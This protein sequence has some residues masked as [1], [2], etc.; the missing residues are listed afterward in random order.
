MLGEL[1]NER[2]QLSDDVASAY[3][4]GLRRRLDTVLV[5]LSSLAGLFTES[6]VR[7]PAWRF[8]ELGRRVERSLCLLSM[9]ETVVSPAHPL[10]RASLFDYVLAA[11]ESLVAYRRRYRSDTVLDA[12]VDLLVR[13]DAN[14]RALHFQL[15]QLRTQ[16]AM[17]PRRDGSAQLA[18]RI[19]AAS[20]ALIEV[21][22]LPSDADH[23]GA[24]GRREAIDRFVHAARTRS[25]TSPT[26]WSS[27]TST[28]RRG[29]ARCSAS[30]D[31]LL[32]ASPHLVSLRPMDEQRSE[33]RPSE[34]AVD[35]EPRRAVNQHRRDTRAGGAIGMER[36]LWQSRQLVHDYRAARDARGGRAIRRRRARV[37]GARGG[38][39]L[40][41]VMAHLATGTNADDID[42]QQF[43]LPSPFIPYLFE[44]HSLA[45]DAFRSHRPFGEAVAML[46]RN[47]HEQYAFDPSFSDVS[48]PLGDVIVHRR[49]V[50]QDF[51]HLMTG[52]M[53]SVGLAARYVSGYIETDPPEGEPKLVGY[54]RVPRVVLGVRRRGTG[55]STPIRPT[56]RFPPGVMSPLRGAATTAM[57]R[58]CGVWCSA[59]PPHRR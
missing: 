19:D 45:R 50:C 43:T 25:A 8:L 42:A 58:R 1:G 56:I 20:A 4:P 22:W 57:S 13:D 21:S 14:P 53:R 33:S 35:A 44:L 32:S 11:N 48:T 49:G 18:E 38:A 2:S 37:T 39:T 15:D 23:V 54:R 36:R 10:V 9:L 17:L 5:H 41:D 12:L 52:A 34:A 16:V 6:T 26:R 59:L 55:G 27:S 46:C 47:I 40:G 29:C 3:D 31:A 51:A 28:T 7:G 24:S 30:T